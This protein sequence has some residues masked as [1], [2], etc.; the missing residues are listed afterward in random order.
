MKKRDISIGSGASG[1]GTL[2]RVC[3]HDVISVTNLLLAW[4]QFS[5]GKRKNPE[6]AKFELHLEHHIFTLH[7][8]LIK[9]TYTPDPYVA[10]VVYDPKR[11]IIHK[12]SVR[13]RVLHQAL[14]QKLYPVFDIHFIHDSYSSRNGKG[15][16]VGVQRLE[17]ACRKETKNWRAPAYALKCDVRK[18]FDSIDKNILQRLLFQKIDDPDIRWLIHK[19]LD[20][21]E[22]CTGKGLPLGNVT[23]QLF[24]NVYMNEF[25]QFIKHIIKAKYYFRYC[26]DFVIV[27]KD[28]DL[29]IEILPKITLFLKEWLLLDVHPYKTSLRKISQGIDFLGYVI[30]P[31]LKTV[32]TSTRRRIIRKLRQVK[33][34]VESGV[35]TEEK[36][37]SVTQSFLGIVSRARDRKLERFLSKMF[38]H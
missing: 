8:V 5:R 25:D 14:F 7:N 30:R 26:D 29:L 28:R 9:K 18:F 24:A 2:S 34:D 4:K 32:R 36:Y 38:N 13:D 33:L 19:N 20:S 31:Y 1:G 10:F 35:I 3:F 6:V 27:F 15:T 23:S 12:A 11:R 37:E 22:T 16:H 21:F 17:R